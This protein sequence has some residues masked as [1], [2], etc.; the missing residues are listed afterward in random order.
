MPRYRWVEPAPIDD[1][2]FA[3]TDY[4]LLSEI[5]ARRGIRDADAARAFLSPSLDQ[6]PDPAELPDLGLAVELVRGAIARGEPIAVFGDYDVD[7]VASTAMLTRG[8]RRRGAV[9]TPYLPH[10]QRDGYGLNAG[11]IERIAAS[12]ARLLLSVD[13]GTGDGD[14]L[15][16]A[17]ERGLTTV[18]LDHHHVA[19]DDLPADAFVSARRPGAGCYDG[20]AAAGVALQFL[21]ALIGD[22]ALQLLPFAALATVADVV[23]LQGPNRALVAL[24]L[25][26]YGEA[27]VGL[28]QLARQAGLSPNRVT[29]WDCG[30]VLGPRLN[31]AGR[32]ADPQLAL[33]LLLCDDATRAGDIALQLNRLNA[34]RQQSLERLVRDAEARLSGLDARVIVLSDPA[35]PVGLVGLA[36]SRLAERHGRPAVVLA[37]HDGLSRG[38]ARSVTGFNIVK[39]LDD[40]RELLVEHGGHSQ[41]AGLTVRTELLGDLSG[42]LSLMAAEALG[43]VSAREPLVLDAEIYAEDLTL[44]TAQALGALEPCGHGNHEPALLLRGARVEHLGRT[45]DGKHLRLRVRAGRRALKAIFF[46]AAAREDELRHGSGVDLAV[47]LKVSRWEG[48]PAPELQVVDCRPGAVVARHGP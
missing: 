6:L 24:G 12:G 17:R 33:D 15:A 30:F 21:R 45:R 13:C 40:C 48:E 32:L 7:G 16:L 20:F 34:Q 3:L 11:A 25:R 31:A 5:L 14:E 29:A 43:P 19:E 27:P 37:E 41:A 26:R 38:S 9:A 35:W 39:A 22:D 36:A 23:P 1:G 4:P 42:R 2:C 46:N 8:L 44:E 10:R 28:L 18:V 47:R